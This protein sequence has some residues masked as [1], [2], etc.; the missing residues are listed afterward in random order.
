[1]P[2]SGPLDQGTVSY[3]RAVA[4]VQLGRTEEAREPLRSAS[5]DASAS[6]DGLGTVLVAP[7]A[8]DLLR[9][10]PPPPAL[11]PAAGK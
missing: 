9:Q 2:A 3:V 6:L 10:L 8:A 5:A 7:L 1:M 11:P 4:L